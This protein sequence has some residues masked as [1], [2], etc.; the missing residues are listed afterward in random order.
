[1][2][3]EINCFRLRNYN[4]AWPILLTAMIV[5]SLS[6]FVFADTNTA[7]NC[8]TNLKPISKK[9]ACS[10]EA[11]NA[12]S[13]GADYVKSGAISELQ[14][15]I[16]NME[17]VFNSNGEI[18]AD[19]SGKLKTDLA[20]LSGSQ[21]TI[22]GSVKTDLTQIK[23]AW[24]PFYKASQKTFQSTIPNLINA[25]NSALAEVDNQFKIVD[26]EKKQIQPG[27]TDKINSALTVIDNN[28][29]P[30]LKASLTKQYLDPLKNE[31]KA[32]GNTETAL[33]TCRTIQE[34]FLPAISCDSA[35]FHYQQS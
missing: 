19:G 25:S 28:K 11:L 13:A 5:W 31:L 3:R 23:T 16:K 7:L 29:A 27:D 4:L 17:N 22:N 2:K 12:P 21:N 30:G 34:S 9:L 35:F 33:S 32:I 24:D 6:S 18:N 10:N 14:K 8:V 26:N 20:A 1:M 15:L